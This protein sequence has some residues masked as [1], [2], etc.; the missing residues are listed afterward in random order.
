MVDHSDVSSSSSSSCDYSHRLPVATVFSFD[1]PLPGQ[2]NQWHCHW[3][4]HWRDH[5]I[6][7]DHWRDQWHCHWRDHW[8]D[9]WIEIDSMNLMASSELELMEDSS[10]MDHWNLIIRWILLDHRMVLDLSLPIASDHDENR[11]VLDL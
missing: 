11:N 10:L 5:W 7:I 4:D 2:R 3:R 1:W 9:H 8:R 6:E